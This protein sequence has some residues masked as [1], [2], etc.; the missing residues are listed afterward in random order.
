MESY[1]PLSQSGFRPGRST[2]DS[3]LSIKLMAST[4]QNKQWSF[5]A[6]CIDMS[7]AFDTISR[8][9]I[10]SVMEGITDADC[11][12]LI[13]VLLSDTTARVRVDGAFSETFT[14]SKGT[15][16]GDSLSPILF[17][18]YLEAC[19]Q[20]ARLRLP[21]RPTEDAN[22]VQETQYADDC[23]FYSTSEDWLKSALPVL[24]EVF[25]DWHLKINNSKTEWL[26]FS[27]NHEDDSWRKSRQLGTLLDDSEEL[28]RRMAL[29][30]AA[31]SSGTCTRHS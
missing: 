30:S 7:R 15:P 9:K 1:L 25:G 10:L 14:L 4:V 8:T 26:H 11:S 18:C 12:R 19:L 5:Y 13:R 22:I 29:A 31:F 2:A 20:E 6:M 3:V 21:P 28:Q 23:N 16:Q 17:T 24:V 27:G